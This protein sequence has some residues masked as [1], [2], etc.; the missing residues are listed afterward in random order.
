[1]NWMFGSKKEHVNKRYKAGPEPRMQFEKIL[2]PILRW[3]V[4]G[5]M[6]ITEHMIEITCTCEL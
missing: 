4:S 1:M 2:K 5:V 6:W 3:N